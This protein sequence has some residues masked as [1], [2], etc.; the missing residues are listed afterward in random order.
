MHRRQL[1]VGELS[2]TLATSREE[3]ASLRKQVDS[4]N[5]ERR[6]VEHEFTRVQEERDGL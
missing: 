6:R 1:Q 4:A 2:A 5:G 3:N